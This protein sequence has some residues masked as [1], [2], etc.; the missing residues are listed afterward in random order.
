M[1]GKPRRSYETWHRPKFLAVVDDT[2]ECTRA[3]YFAARRAGR[4][5][6]AVEQVC[7]LANHALEH[8]RLDEAEELLQ[9]GLK[10]APENLHLQQMR[11]NVIRGLGR[12]DELMVR[13]RDMADQ[14]IADEKEVEAIPV[15]EQIRDLAPSR[16]ETR[17]ELIRL[18]KKI[19]DS[20]ATI[21]ESTGLV[22]RVSSNYGYTVSIKKYLDR[23]RR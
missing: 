11:M 10:L 3:V 21:R 2:P 15:V 4:M 13:L 7:W 14:L 19:G 16:I 8:G 1:P 22:T 9:E 12:V 5:E 20:P 6:A 18:H 23:R 17:L